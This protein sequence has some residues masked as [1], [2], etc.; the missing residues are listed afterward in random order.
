MNSDADTELES[1]S[2][3][4]L[5]LPAGLSGALLRPQA[6]PPLSYDVAAEADTEAEEEV[7]AAEEASGSGGG[8]SSSSSSG[9]APRRVA[10]VRRPSLRR[11]LASPKRSLRRP[12][13]FSEETSLLTIVGAQ[14]VVERESPSGA[15]HG[16]ATVFWQRV[17]TQLGRD[18]PPEREPAAVW[19]R[20]AELD[21]RAAVAA[22][23]SEDEEEAGESEEEESEGEGEVEGRIH[24]RGEGATRQSLQWTFQE[25]RALRALM[26]TPSF[27]SPPRGGLGSLRVSG[28]ASELRGGGAS[29]STVRADMLSF[30][31]RVSAALGTE[32]SAQQVNRK[33]LELAEAGSASHVSDDS[34]SDSEESAEAA[35]GPRRHRK[36]W[37]PGEDALLWRLLKGRVHGDVN[38][39][40][41]V[42]SSD[43]LNLNT[44]VGKA[45]FRARRTARKFWRAVARSLAKKFPPLRKALAVWKRY[46]AGE[47]EKG[48]G[49]VA[50]ASIMESRKRKRV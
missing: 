4:G 12:W 1:L 24:G 30:W 3:G 26:A 11:R 2:G 31:T 37:E 23:E 45:A 13:G 15:R 7:A 18:H 40:T 28:A 22:D 48:T 17:A 32:R 43:L 25:E 41:P 36:P 8:G 44:A 20:W 35:E 16:C 38:E 10:S 34:T 47:A 14:G 21:P 29:L 49:K 46:R 39:R 42:S 33:W 50:R 6:L 5:V 27:C 9:A 19:A